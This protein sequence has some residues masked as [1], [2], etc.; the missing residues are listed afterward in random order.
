MC[1]LEDFDRLALTD[2]HRQLVR[3]EWYIWHKLY[4][5]SGSLAV[6]DPF[7]NGKEVVDLGAGCGETALLFLNHG[8]SRVHCFENDPEALSLLKRNF[9]DNPRV[10]INFS[11]VGFVKVDIEGSE[12]RMVVESHFPARWF[13]MLEH[14]GIDLWVLRRRRFTVAKLVHRLRNMN[15]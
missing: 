13:K 9:G 7:L 15:R 2:Y 10:T 11:T 5:P 4:L 1:K 14:D 8:A 3:D 6:P 12:E